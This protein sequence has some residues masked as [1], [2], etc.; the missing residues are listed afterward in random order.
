MP[1]KKKKGKGKD[2]GGKGGGLPLPPKL[3]DSRQGA[4]EALLSFRYQLAEFSL[5]IYYSTSFIVNVSLRRIHGKED[6]IQQYEEEGEVFKTK[7]YELKE[8]VPNMM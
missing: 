4:L 3:E 1:G 6:V 8:K 7:N 5:H 2:K